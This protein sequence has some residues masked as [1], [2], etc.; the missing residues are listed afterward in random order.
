ML[1]SK[2]LFTLVGLV[3]AIFAICRLDLN[4]GS[5]VVENWWNAGQ[6]ST[7]AQPASVNPNTGKA[8]ALGVSVLNE[9]TLGSGKFVQV[10]SYQAVLSPRFSNVQYGANI[11]YNMPSRENM[12]VPCDPLTFGNMANEKFIL[13][14][15]IEEEKEGFSTCGKGGYG[16]GHKVGGGDELPPSYAAGNYWD[17]Y[18]KIPAKA[19]NMGSKL[20]VGTMTTMD[21]AGNQEQFVT[22]N[23]L[24]VGLLKPKR[25]FGQSDWI[26]G[27]LAITPCNTGWFSVYPDI[28][29][30]VNPGAMG[31]LSGP[32]GGGESNN[33][34]LDLLVKASGGTR[35]TFGG[36]DLSNINSQTVNQNAQMTS[37]VRAGLSDLQVTAFP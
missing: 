5:P 28:T 15:A 18:N 36:V 17:E 32:G 1:S 19:E 35:T 4:S 24:M 8:T 3:V 2:F 22:Y 27:D 14:G 9:N 11:K 23:N 10:P 26:R 21:A 29:R 13:P 12:A 16:L 30:E 37:K 7:Y 34:T 33:S 6:F 31:V 20:P 25:N